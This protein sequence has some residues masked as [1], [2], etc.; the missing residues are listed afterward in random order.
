MVKR[1]VLNEDAEESTNEGEGV[2]EIGQRVNE[3]AEVE[4]DENRKNFKAEIKTSEITVANNDIRSEEDRE[5]IQNIIDIMRSEEKEFISGF[6]KVERWKLV[7]LCNKELNGKAKTGN[8][9]PDSEESREFWS[10]IWSKQETHRDNAEWLTELRNNKV[11]CQ[12]EKFEIAVEMVT[13]QCKKLPNWKAPGPD[14]VQGFWLKK[15]HSL[16]NRIATQM[17]DIINNNISIPEWMTKGRT[18]LCQKDTAKGNEVGNFR[19]ISCLPLM[20]KFMT[21][22]VSEKIYSYLEVNNILPNEQKGCRKKSKGTKDQL[23]IDKTILRDCKKKHK[24]LA[25]AWVDYKKAYD[26]VPHS[27]ILESMKLINIS[28]SVIKFIQG[29]MSKWKTELTACGCAMKKEKVSIILLVNVPSWRKESIK[30]DTTMWQVHFVDGEP[31]FENPNPTLK[32]GYGKP[33]KL[34]RRKLSRPDLPLPD[35]SKKED[36][37][38]ADNTNIAVDCIL[39]TNYFE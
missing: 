33:A 7:N 16:H 39:Y 23:L 24:N 13:Q 6:K 22:I 36:D 31:T 25:M 8:A 26:M 34:Q 9:V 1:Y 15:M 37:A 17:N 3:N 14:G 32:L 19:P 20:W 30:E 11:E 35:V 18:V 28:E 2:M 21:E 12:Q 27:W 29:S 38:T 5:I 10:N 4:N